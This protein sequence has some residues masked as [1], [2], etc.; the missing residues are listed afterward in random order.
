MS[1]VEAA[2]AIAQ[3]AEATELADAAAQQAEASLLDQ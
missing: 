1:I 2:D 3:Q